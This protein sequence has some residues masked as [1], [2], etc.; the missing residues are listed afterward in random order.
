MVLKVSIY[1]YQI[2]NKLMYVG[3]RQRFEYQMARIHH[4]DISTGDHQNGPSTLRK[5]AAAVG[6]RLILIRRLRCVV[7]I[8]G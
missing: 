3:K 6:E 1:Y 7:L 4:A 2:F 8:L 5:Q